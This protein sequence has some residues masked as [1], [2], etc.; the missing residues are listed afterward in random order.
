MR[1]LSPELAEWMIVEGYGKVLSRPQL[2]PVERELCTVAALTVMDWERQLFSHIKGALNV[3][4]AKNEVKEAI[5]QASLFA[6]TPA[7][8]KG[9]Q[10]L[11]QC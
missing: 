8:Q 3:G 9:L 10:L 7:S 1:E 5:L 11:N 2:S 6:G 4:A